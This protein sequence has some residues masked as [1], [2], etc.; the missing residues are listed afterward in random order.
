MK[1]SLYTLHELRNCKLADLAKDNYCKV[2]V[3]RSKGQRN[4]MVTI[5]YSSLP[6]AGFVPMAQL[7]NFLIN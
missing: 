6:L 5:T 4:T 3:A 1:Q 7:S 2:K